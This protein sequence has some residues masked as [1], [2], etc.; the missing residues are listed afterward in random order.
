MSL[1]VLV[2]GAGPAGLVAALELA[3]R[4]VDVRLIEQA[5][6]PASG[7]RA[8]GI[9]PRTL[10]VFESLGVV[11]EVLTSGGPFPPWRNYRA[12]RVAWEKSI[13]ELLGIGQPAADPAVPYPETWMIPQWRTEE[14][15]RGALRRLGV[16]IEYHSAL[17]ALADDGAG[18]TATIRRLGETERLR[19]SFVVA[20]DGA[21]STL[22]KILGV[23]FD[24]VT[25]DDER[26]LT[27]DV[28]TTGLDRSYWH[29]WSHP[30]H[31]A[32][33]VSI[34][35]LPG[36]DT[37]QFVA[38]LLPGENMPVLELA[39]LQRLFDERS[40]GVAV[41]FD[42]APWITVSRTN[43]RLASR[44]RVGRVFLVGDAAHAVPA[45]G[46]QGL[47]TAVQDSHNLG[48]KLAMVLR[49]APERLLDSYEEE[50]YPIAAR[51]MNGLKAA[52]DNQSEVADV[53]QLRN[54]Y[55]GLWLSEETR[56]DP[57]TLRAGDRAPDAP[58]SLPDGSRPRLFEFLQDAEIT[59]LAFGDE[60]VKGCNDIVGQR[61][62]ANACRVL[63]VRN[64]SPLS[65]D[66]IQAIYGVA[67]DKESLLVV[68]PDWHIGLAA[69]NHFA[70]RLS[71]Y[72]RRLALN[73]MT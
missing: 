72:L 20:A 35:P 65:A 41:T 69:E 46:G 42:D 52:A 45:A 58:L 8:K 11:E 18:V 33:R 10:E 6:A 68:R 22:R 27:A 57:G 25:R 13:Y 59:A 67:P 44:F 66:A 50:R 61:N 17:I 62:P 16:E 38:P 39:T 24:G 60:A 63:D 55:R 37:Y 21:A 15:L 26:F 48:W 71:Q 40:E 51:L 23:A 43:E 2:V 31:P 7:S 70:E 53:F 14:I 47:N 30:D 4:R 64:E 49:G 19:S 1:S 12:G 3:R 5:A 9:Q 34:C 54:N 32:A 28:R 36:T 56:P 73:G 29:N